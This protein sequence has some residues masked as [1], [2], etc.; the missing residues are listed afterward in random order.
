MALEFCVR[1]LRSRHHQHQT[2]RR[3][4]SSDAFRRVKMANCDLEYDRNSDSYSFDSSS[5]SSPL[6]HPA[7]ESQQSKT[8]FN[9]RLYLVSPH[10]TH[11]TDSERSSLLGHREGIPSYVSSP[12][13]EIPDPF[14]GSA[15]APRPLG[16]LTRK[17]SRVFNSKAYD[18]DSNKNSLA[19]VGSGERVWYFLG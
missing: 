9:D 14:E 19:A 7:K 2:P 6:L 11:F 3:Y 16:L 12:R 15:T 1:S 10:K 17:I 13:L 8:S 5:T 4:P 18:Y